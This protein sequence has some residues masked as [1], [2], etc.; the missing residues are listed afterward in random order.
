MNKLPK[1]VIRFFNIPAHFK[2]IF[3]KTKITRYKKRKAITYIGVMLLAVIAIGTLVFLYLQRLDLDNLRSI[4]FNYRDPRLIIGSLLLITIS[5]L[6]WRVTGRNQKREL[7]KEKI[8]EI[9]ICEIILKD[10]R[11]RIIRKWQV[12]DA[13]AFLI[14]KKTKKNMVNIDLSESTYA[15]LISREHAVLNKTSG[16]WYFEDINSS[17]GSGIKRGKNGNK[18]KVKPDTPYKIYSGDTIYIANTK[19]L[20]K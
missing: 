16:G 5:I 8:K 13:T 2:K 19:L 9:R 7:S 10:K 11:D 12:R 3:L 20:I 18:F 17:N 6:I 14:G 1:K 4:R 15:P